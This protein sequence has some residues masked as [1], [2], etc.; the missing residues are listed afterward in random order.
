MNQTFGAQ[1]WTR[2]ELGN[3]HDLHRELDAHLAVDT[4]P[5]DAEGAPVVVHRNENDGV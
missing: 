4:P 3:I 2:S 1:A 5:D